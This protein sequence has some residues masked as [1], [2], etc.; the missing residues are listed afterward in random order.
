M[1]AQETLHD[2]EGIG[3]LGR[4]RE[5]AFVG[6]TGRMAVGIAAGIVG[7]IVEENNHHQDRGS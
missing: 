3:S 6:R 4:E 7:G 1:Q 5:V 2:D